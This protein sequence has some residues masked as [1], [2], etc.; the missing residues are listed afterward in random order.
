MPPEQFT[1]YPCVQRV[2][3]TSF[4]Y[5]SRLP[6]SARNGDHTDNMLIMRLPV[7]LCIVKLGSDLFDALHAYGL[8]VLLAHVTGEFVEL[9]NEGHLYR[10]RCSATVP[11]D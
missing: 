4:L 8:G 10:L 7:E 1:I 6:D 2:G 9:H 11:S 3:T 5:R